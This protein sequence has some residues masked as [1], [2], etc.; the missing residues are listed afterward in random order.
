M[1]Q[2]IK[3]PFMKI[4]RD[5]T[6]HYE[7]KGTGNS[8]VFIHP[9]GMGLKTFLC[10]K[11]L[12]KSC[13]ML[14]FDMRGNGLSKSGSDPVT[15]SLL[16]E[17]L[18]LLLDGL[19]IQKAVI[20]GY[21]NGGAIAQEFALSY[22]ER[23]NGLVLIGGFPE[24]NTELLTLEFL[25]GIYLSG[26]GGMALLAAAISKG[27]AP[28]KMLRSLLYDSFMRTDPYILYQMY[29]KTFH[30][31]STERLHT[32]QCPLL[33]VYGEKDYYVHSY[34]ALFRKHV[35]NTASVYVSG[36]KHQVPTKNPNELN[37]ILLHF[38]RELKKY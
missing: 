35:S 16:A 4:R 8:L 34:E 14:T 27:H 38:L 12:S 36:V 37:R 1:R 9:T 26:F 20:C 11:A 28:N 25:L 30:Y 6:L 2:V 18:L 31:E 19:G 7:L 29:R 24:V 13:R 33:L 22:P 5:V 17:D 23:T 21:S 3:M 32:L 15:I 10:Q